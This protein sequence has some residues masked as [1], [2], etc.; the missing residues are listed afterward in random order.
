MTGDS[1]NFAHLSKYKYSAF[2]FLNIDKNLKRSAL[3]STGTIDSTTC[4][5]YIS[6]VIS[7]GICILKLY[8]LWSKQEKGINMCYHPLK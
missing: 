7:L 4:K 1:N 2:P 3:S 6:L 5:V 8:I